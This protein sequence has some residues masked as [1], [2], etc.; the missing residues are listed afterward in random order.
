M[1]T[2][3]ENE[4]LRLREDKVVDGICD[5]SAVLSNA[6]KVE[7]DYFVAPPGNIPVN[8]DTDYAKLEDK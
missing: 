7:E 3:L 1:F 8:I 4:T 6:E 2:V 5:K